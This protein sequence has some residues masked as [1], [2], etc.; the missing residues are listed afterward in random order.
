MLET[1]ALIDLK[2]RGV[3]RNDLFEPPESIKP[4]IHIARAS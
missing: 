1:E 3:E 2:A 4:W